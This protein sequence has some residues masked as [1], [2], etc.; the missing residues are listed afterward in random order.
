MNFSAANTYITSPNVASLNIACDDVHNNLWPLFQQLL[1]TN[2]EMLIQTSEWTYAK[3]FKYAVDSITKEYAVTV[4]DILERE[5][6]Q[7]NFCFYFI[8]YIHH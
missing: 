8:M 2:Y 7:K 1:T 5:D 3:P 4:G 6:L